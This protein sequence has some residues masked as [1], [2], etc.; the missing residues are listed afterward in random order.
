M[1]TP[2]MISKRNG[3]KTDP[4]VEGPIEEVCPPPFLE[5][6]LNKI[7]HLFCLDNTL[8]FSPFFPFF[9]FPLVFGPL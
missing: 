2:E 1:Y 9:I 8:E 7:D 3:L 4:I 6:L 5:C